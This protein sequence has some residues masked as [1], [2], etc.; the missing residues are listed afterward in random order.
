MSATVKNMSKN[1]KYDSKILLGI[2]PDGS[3][4]VQVQEGDSPSVAL[5]YLHML[6]QL[7][8]IPLN[9]STMDEMGYD[10]PTE[11]EL[12]AARLAVMDVKTGGPWLSEV[13][14]A[15]GT[16]MAA[17]GQ[18]GTPTTWTHTYRPLLRDFRE[19]VSKTKRT[20]TN[21]EGRQEDIWDIRSRELDEE[22]IKTYCAAMARYPMSYGSTKN[23][24]DAKQALNAGLPPQSRENSQKKIRMLKTFLRWAD[25]KKKLSDKLYIFIPKEPTDRKRDKSKDGYQPW[26]EKELKILFERDT[27]AS[28]G[29]TWKFWT[30]LLGLYAGGRANELAQL[31][32]ADV[33]TT[34]GGIPCILITD[35][36]D[37]DE[38]DDTPTAIQ[39][40]VKTAAS[41][42]WVPIHPKLIEIGFLRYVEDMKAKGETRLFP[43]LPF[44]EAS[45]Y[46]KQVSKD[47][48]KVTRSLGIWVNRK[49]VFHSFRG[50][51]NGRLMKL[52]MPQELREFIL[53]HTNE[54]TNVKNYGKQLED[55]PYDV[56]LTWLSKVDFGLTHKKWEPL[57]TL[58][59]I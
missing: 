34:T 10:N 32:V 21:K 23:H 49:K 17:I 2:N 38:D 58:P 19:L 25:Q 51:L 3:Y 41:R 28:G 39:K 26:T 55:R 20:V 57:H 24:G 53:G 4:T 56:L 8:T 30:P 29:T 46:G 54:S 43:E 47:F 35:L 5:E 59:P 18:W 13:I 7:G 37:E 22:H 6:R 48:G 33:F 16:E 12:R 11:S 40:S 31:L 9:S 42:R 50:T 36:E 15:Y 52:G 27:Y 14:D 44:I 45:K 1:D